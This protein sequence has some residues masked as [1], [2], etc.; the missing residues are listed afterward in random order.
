V[1]LTSTN[2]ALPFP[3]LKWAGGKRRMAGQVISRMPSKICTYYE[4]FIGGGAVFFELARQKRFV[5]AHIGDCNADLVTA[6]KTVRD[7]VEALISELKESGY[8]YNKENYLRVRA[9][10]PNTLS[11]VKRSARFLFL[12]KT[13]FNGLYRVNKHGQFNVP[14]GKYDNPMIC[15]EQNLRA[16]SETLKGVEISK[17][18]FEEM[19]HAPKEG[20]VVYLDPPY[21]PASK[22]SK[23]TAY[24][25]DGFT[26]DDHKRLA[27]CFDGLVERKVCCVLSNSFTPMTIELY[28]KHNILELMGARVVGGPAA[29]RKPAKE[30]IVW[31]SNA[32]IKV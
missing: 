22:T 27:A 7:N 3:F 24:S 31:S 6:Y 30:I 29:Y 32:I 10:D 5:Q 17:V 1:T 11:V 21:M 16:A 19:L 4:P 13:C 26:E 12:N 28:S 18:D 15:D 20:D 23:F 25:I 9:V 2:R 8:E 14:F